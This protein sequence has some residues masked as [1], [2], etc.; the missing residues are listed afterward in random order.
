[1]SW[2]LYSGQNPAER[3]EVGSAILKAGE[4]VP[5]EL[6][7]ESLEQVELAS[8]A[9][10][11]VADGMKSEK[12]NWTASGHYHTG[13]DAPSMISVSVSEFVPREE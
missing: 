13:Q 6:S 10:A 3:G 9:A 7:A 12:V 1:M 5:Y 8:K 11:V 2:S 4:D